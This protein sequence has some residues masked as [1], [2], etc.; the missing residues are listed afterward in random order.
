MPPIAAPDLVTDR[1]R[2]LAE[3]LGEERGMKHGWKSAV[4]DEL[5]VSL[6]MLSGVLAGKRRVGWSL[7]QNAAERI[8]ID[9]RFFSG[10]G[11]PRGWL[12]LLADKR[13]PVRPHVPARAFVELRALAWELEDLRERERPGDVMRAGRQLA[14]A[15]LDS[16]PVLKAQAVQ[17]SVPGSQEERALVLDLIESL[18]LPEVSASDLER[19]ERRTS[20]PSVAFARVSLRY[21]Q[22]AGDA[23]RTLARRFRAAG[24]PLGDTV[25]QHLLAL[26]DDPDDHVAVDDGGQDDELDAPEAMLAL[27]A[28]EAKAKRAL[29]E[30]A[31]PPSAT[32]H[33]RK[34][35]HTKKE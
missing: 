13:D 6:P 24:T 11:D 27:G 3:W 9:H 30:A 23:L 19:L 12:R 21:V 33:R 16:L 18:L 2:L 29:V 26:L 10:E 35:L 22:D 17:A 15:V 20:S 34:N 1:F 14:V 32:R 31:R 28:A 7:A 4:A 8:G 25:R 5:G